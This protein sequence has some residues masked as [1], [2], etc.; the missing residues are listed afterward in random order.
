MSEGRRARGLPAGR[1]IRVFQKL[2]FEVDRVTGSHHIIDGRR[3][4]IPGHRTVKTGLLLN[5]LKKT[6]ITWEEFRD[7]L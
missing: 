1:V 7:E 3:V 4:S 2:G 5:Q 6:G